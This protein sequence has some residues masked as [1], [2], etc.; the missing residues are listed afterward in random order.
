MTGKIKAFQKP[1]GG[2]EMFL[3]LEDYVRWVWFCYFP[4]VM[5]F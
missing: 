1:G 3:S 4:P 2:M 5:S